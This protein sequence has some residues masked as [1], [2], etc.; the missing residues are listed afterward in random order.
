M[1]SEGGG[2]WRFL[3]R[4]TIFS[5]QV[6]VGLSK[7]SPDVEEGIRGRGGGAGHKKIP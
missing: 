6:L 2:L 3:G 4:G 5:C 1:Q 7:I